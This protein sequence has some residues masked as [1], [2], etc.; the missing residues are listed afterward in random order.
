[1]VHI[2]RIRQLSGEKTL[3]MFFPK[4]L[5]PI[6]TKRFDTASY[7]VTLRYV[8]LRYVTFCY[9]ML[10]K[11]KFHCGTLRFVALRRVVL[12]CWSVNKSNR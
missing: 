1:M 12:H 11:I 4:R 10:R 5:E 2:F 7:I 9:V 6:V 3:E 8:T